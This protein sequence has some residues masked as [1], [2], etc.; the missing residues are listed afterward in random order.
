MTSTRRIALLSTAGLFAFNSLVAV[1]A[2]AGPVRLWPAKTACEGRIA[3]HQRGEILECRFSVPPGARSIDVDFNFE[4]HAWPTEIDIG[5]R[6]PEGVQGWSEDRSD[7]IHIDA[8]T[9]S[10]GF[11][12]GLSQPGNWA[13]LIGVANVPEGS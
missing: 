12:P 13:L 9:A 1:Y 3:R 5:I 11:L 7:H 4:P 8:I 10:L 6:S 2:P